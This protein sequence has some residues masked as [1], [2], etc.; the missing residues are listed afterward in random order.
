MTAKVPAAVVV[1]CQ[2]MMVVAIAAS[3]M[4]TRRQRHGG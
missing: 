3:A 4:L 2:G 1:I